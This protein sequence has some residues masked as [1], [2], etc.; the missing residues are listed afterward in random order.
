MRR[1]LLTALCASVL[2]AAPAHAAQRPASVP[3]TT[4]DWPVASGDLVGM[5]LYAVTAHGVRSLRADVTFA[6]VPAVGTTFRA[7]VETK[8]CGWWSLSVNRYGTPL[9]N[10]ALERYGCD[11]TALAAPVETGPATF[12]VV[13]KTVRITA[14]YAL[15]L[16]RGA[17]LVHGTALAS[18]QY[19]GVLV[20]VPPAKSVETGDYADNGID[21]VLP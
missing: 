15:G 3:D 14:P 20:A 12:T 1:H 19:A 21:Y 17:R 11:L 9:Q 10:A 8:A 6:D 16:G 5:R 13:G 2:L 18:M 7:I 4:G